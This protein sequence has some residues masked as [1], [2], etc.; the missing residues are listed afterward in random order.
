MQ[1]LLTYTFNIV[2]ATGTAYVGIGFLLGLINLWKKTGEV[3]E[4]KAIS[5]RTLA[6][7]AATAPQ[8]SQLK[9]VSKPREAVQVPVRIQEH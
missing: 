6:L 3:V 1:A 9:P 5:Q 2:L 4:A 7:P 8:V